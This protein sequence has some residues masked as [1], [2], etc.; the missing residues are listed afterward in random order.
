[1]TLLRRGPQTQTR[2][3]EPAPCGITYASRRSSKRRLY[4]V[5]V[6]ENCLRN[7]STSVIKDALLV[8]PCSRSSTHFPRGP[9]SQA[10]SGEPAPR[11]IACPLSELF[12][13]HVQVAKPPVRGGHTKES[14]PYPRSLLAARP[15][16][17]GATQPGCH[18]IQWPAAN[19]SSGSRVHNPRQNLSL[20][21][22]QQS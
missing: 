13:E 14:L 20:P 16:R 19:E 5:E 7:L 15:C 1:V 10:K 22:P 11:G 21:L 9:Q 17:V 2:S 8:A 6:E 4:S 18:R 12:A 3:G